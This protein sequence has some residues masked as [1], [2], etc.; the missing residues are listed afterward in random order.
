MLL[1][2]LL[3]SATLVP[4][5]TRR[6]A[7]RG[8]SSLSALRGE[9]SASV[10]DLVEGA[11]ELFA[12]GATE[13]QL[14]GIEASDRRLEAVARQRAGTTG[15]GLALTT[16][17]AGAA[18]WGALTLGVAATHSGHLDG[19]LVGVLALVPLAAF[20]LVAPLPAA[21]QALERTRAAA[22]RVFEVVEAPPAV[23]EPVQP[24]QLPAGPHGV[25]LAS[26]WATYPGAGRPALH[27]IDLVLQP[28]RRV[29]LVGRSGA[30]KSTIAD[31]LVKFLPADSRAATIDGVPMERLRAD[32]VRRV[33]GLVEQ[34]P[35]LFDTTLAENLRI[36]RRSAGDDELAD[37]LARVGL[38][39]WLSGLPRGLATEVG[40]SGAGSP[41]VSA[42]GWQWPGH[43]WPSS[44]CWC[45]T[46]RPS[47]SNPPRQTPLPLMCSPS[48]RASA[49]CSSP[50]AWP[51]SST[52]TR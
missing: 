15:V 5:L 25:E 33:I 13:A 48:P 51:A 52:W 31:I 50:T 27:D 24:V 36:G 17:L 46:N 10:V 39:K 11:P 28:G 23:P 44:R 45:S 30:G 2:A 38:G 26:V 19:A 43:C 34:R 32:D 37:V 4:W 47:T 22:G 9:L 3:L 16:A 42:S 35:H 21:T 18:S 14:A 20:E 6:L 12:M 8:E 40:P 49:S 7:A 29:A 1:G 41:G